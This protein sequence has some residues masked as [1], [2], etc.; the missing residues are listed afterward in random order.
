MP[1]NPLPG[2]T[3]LTNGDGI[4][5]HGVWPQKLVDNNTYSVTA[6][7]KPKNVFANWVGGIVQPYSVLSTSA[8]IS[9]FM[10]SNLVLEANFTTNVFVAAQGTY[11]GLFAPADSARQQTNSGSFIFTVTSTGTI[12]GHLDLGGVSEPLSG[13]FEP[14]GSAEIQSP[15]AHGLPWV[16]TVLQLDFADRSVSGVVSDS[17]FT[18]NLSGYQDV[19]S[20]IQ[21]AT[22]FKGQYTLVI[23]SAD[24]PSIGPF[25]TSYGTVHV[26]ASGAVTL[27]GS[28]A[29]G[30]AISQSSAVSQQGY[31]PM[32]VSLYG[33]KGSLWGTN[34]FTN[35]TV[36]NVSAISWINETNSSKT[37]LYRSGFTNQNATLT[38]GIYDSSNALPT[39]LAATMQETNPAI[40]IT[41]TNLSENTNELTLKT[42][43]TTGVITGSFAYPGSSKPTVKIHGIILQNETN[44]QGYFLGPNH[45]GTFSLG[46]Q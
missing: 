12:S 27:T 25:G 30:T 18:A 3:L 38:G 28:L 39:D 45:S 2:L 22:A 4:I 21:P 5:Q 36:T 42:N 11:R 23:P 40:T 20:G 43:K 41:V 14:G 17:D 8:T 16:T 46:P 1:T 44:A 15:P 7:P 35:G 32:Y 33:G 10:Q 13:K 26:S 31:W 24:D 29:D 19:F 34:I 37:A 6:V 9:F